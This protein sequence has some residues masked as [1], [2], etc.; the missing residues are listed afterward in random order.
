MFIRK[1]LLIAALLSPVGAACAEE[2]GLQITGASIRGSRISQEVRCGECALKV[3]ASQAT[4]FQSD[5][6]FPEMD[7]GFTHLEGGSRVSYQDVRELQVER[8][9]PGNFHLR[10]DRLNQDW[11]PLL[12]FSGQILCAVSRHCSGSGGGR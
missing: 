9:A 1:G 11:T 7:S 2:P 6:I 12:A 10:I 3:E 8:L 5:R 4:R